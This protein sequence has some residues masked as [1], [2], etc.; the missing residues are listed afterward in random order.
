M[1]IYFPSTSKKSS[2]N[3]TLVVLILFNPEQ[4]ISYD[5]AKLKSRRFLC[6]HMVDFASPVTNNVIKHI[7]AFSC[8][9]S[10]TMTP[11]NYE[12]KYSFI[13]LLAKISNV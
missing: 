5:R 3:S 7:A 8:N 9:L 4:N 10:A 12:Q 11:F 2:L 6:N 1:S 13:L